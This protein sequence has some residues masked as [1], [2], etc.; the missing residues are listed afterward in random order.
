MLQNVTEGLRLG[1]EYKQEKVYMRFGC[2]ESLL[3][4]FIE[5]SKE[6]INKV[7]VTF[8]GNTDHMGHGWH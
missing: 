7:K 1:L 5:N 2:Q 8:S 4:R 6:G 3:V